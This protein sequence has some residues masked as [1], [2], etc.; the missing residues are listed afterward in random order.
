M[1]FTGNRTRRKSKITKLEGAENAGKYVHGLQMYKIPPTDNI[2]L[3]EFEEFAID[4]LKV[5]REVETFGIRYKRNSEQYDTAMKESLKKFLPQAQKLTRIEKSTPL[6]GGKTTSRISFCALHIAD[7]KISGDGFCHKR[8]R[9]T[10]V[11]RFDGQEADAFLQANGLSYTPIDDGERDDKKSEL[12]DSGFNLTIDKVLTTDYFKVRFV[13]A[14]DLVR[15]R[16]GFA[17]VPREELVSLVANEFRMQLSRAL[18]MTARALPYLEEDERLLPKLTNLSRQYVGQDYNCK[19]TAGGKVTVDQIDGLSRSAYPLCMRQLHTALKENHHLKH[20]GRLQYG[21]FLKGI[22]L[23]LEEA[24]I[25]WRAEFTKLMDVDKFDKQYAYN[26]RHNYGKEGK[27]ADYTPY[28]CMK[29][30]M[31]NPQ[32]LEII[33][34]LI[35]VL[36]KLIFTGCPFRHTDADLLRQRLAAYRVPKKGADEIMEFVK[37]S[38]YQLACTRY[39]ELTHGVTASSAIN[40]PNQYFDESRQSL[41][42]GQGGASRL[43]STTQSGLEHGKVTVKNEINTTTNADDTSNAPVNTNTNDDLADIQMDDDDDILG[44]IEGMDTM[45]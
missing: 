19:K 37:E 12:K 22:G 14:L 18:A 27:R 5:L 38:H 45:A 34:E 39:Y 24:L 21:L 44:E 13:E 32:D 9:F 43:G 17:Y 26:I 42:E 8:F 2:T 31:S 16:K 3:E 15:S 6:R 35:D 23:S 25:F 10:E 40:H 1:Q 4:R 20:G 36:F 41:Q 7:R 33:M 11:A 28:S 29:I 30:I